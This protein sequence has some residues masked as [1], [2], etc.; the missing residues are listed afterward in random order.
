MDKLKIICSEGIIIFDAPEYFMVNDTDG[1]QYYFEKIEEELDKFI[2][3]RYYVD[4]LSYINL[5]VKYSCLET[6]LD[7]IRDEIKKTINKLYKYFENK[8]GFVQKIAINELNN[9]A[10]KF[11]N[12]IQLLQLKSHNYKE[13]ECLLFL[14]EHDMETSTCYHINENTEW[15]LMGIEKTHN[16]FYL[17]FI[18]YLGYRG[19]Y[20]KNKNL[21]QIKNELENLNIST[22]NS[23]KAYIKKPST[24]KG[25]F[26]KDNHLKIRLARAIK[27]NYQPA[28][29]VVGVNSLSKDAA[30]TI[31]DRSV[32]QWGKLT[33]I[34][35][36]ALLNI[37]K[38]V[39]ILNDELSDIF[40]DTL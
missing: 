4:L 38:S 5:V 35:F 20:N 22:I 16:K 28:T 18:G 21:D 37:Q 34:D 40:S 30:E 32:K 24:Y 19:L 14:D 39:K 11:R 29:N 10:R 31:Y 1:N 6:E 7:F 25:I 3:N 13:E 26:N 9:I 8:G 36:M 15:H 17:A 2:L 33:L 27:Q 23:S 12:G